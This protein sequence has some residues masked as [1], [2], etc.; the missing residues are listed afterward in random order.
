M[1]DGFVKVA[2]A[3]PVIRL[4]DCDYNAERVIETM[5]ARRICDVYWQCCAWSRRKSPAST[6]YQ[7]EGQYGP[8]AQ[9]MYSLLGFWVDINE[10]ENPAKA[11]IWT[12][13]DRD[14]TGE[15][16]YRALTD[17]TAQLPLPAWAEKE[18]REAEEMGI[19]DGTRPCALIPRYQAAI[20][21]KRAVEAALRGAGK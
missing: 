19:T 8:E 9:R 7:K 12:K 21:A 20:M 16:I 6:V 5:R 4:A 18:L 1:R 3:S 13:E 14:M 15:E 10:T 2:A 17:Y 11:G